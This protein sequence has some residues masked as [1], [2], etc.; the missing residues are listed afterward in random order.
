MNRIKIVLVF[1]MITFAVSCGQQKKY[2]EYTVK[3][4]ETMGT[5]AKDLGINTRY[6]LRLNPDVSR[7]PDP[8]TIIII[9][10]PKKSKTSTNTEA[11][12]NIDEGKDE[13]EEVKPI[14]DD[15]V[16][17]LEALR[18]EFVVHEV[19]PKET[20]Y[21]LKRFY[22]VSEEDLLRLN[23]ILS[24]GL[25]IGQFIKI[26]PIVEGKKS[27]N[28]RYED[29]IKE[30]ASLKV[31][32]LLPFITNQYDSVSS[33]DIFS[34]SVLVN[35]ATDFYLGAE[36]AIDSLKNQGI[37]IEL[38]VFDT[39]RNSSKIKRILAEHNLNANDVIIGPL[40]SEEAKIVARKV[41]VPVIFPFYSK[42]QYKFSSSKLIKASPEKKVFREELVTYIKD[43]FN[44]GN[45][46]IVGDGKSA[47]NLNSSK[48]KK[49]LEN[50]N[51]TTKVHILKP[52]KG[53]IK[54]QL[55]LD[56][57]KPDVKNWVL[58]ATNDNVVVA[59]AINS[60]ISL[61]KATSV[62]VFSFDKGVAF[63]KIDNFKLAKIGFTYVSDQYVD[64]TY[65]TTQLFNK[66]YF[67]KN[68]ALPS[69]Y[70]TKGFDIVYDI[71]MRL[72]SGENLKSTF[73]KGASYRVESKFDYQKELFSTS[74]NKGLFIVQYN[75]DLTLKRLK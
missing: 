9:P 74:E 35:I 43:H 75:E 33:K 7:K 10:S 70:A 68:N 54:K 65:T 38:N 63:D 61:P 2:I 57:L 47:S 3:Q 4:G 18:K 29:F 51:A 21:G 30:N 59:D 48:I 73:N 50:H 55:F 45:L 56:I 42:D 26:K 37:D 12:T 5:I 23:P 64:E 25:K 24:E 32:L 13:V 66:Q 17:E 15:K 19:K 72:A 36:I 16:K 69:F 11:E 1:C 67:T 41:N 71:L 20:I 28:V 8:N 27:E 52:E 49:T 39:G 46:I 6:L 22:N 53:Y 58:I 44:S 40:Y 60:L 62:K 31:A 34:K 14:D